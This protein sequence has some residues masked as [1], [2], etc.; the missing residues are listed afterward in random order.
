MC[1]PRPKRR[2]FERPQTI[3][4]TRNSLLIP[5]YVLV[6][7]HVFLFHGL[8]WTFLIIMRINV[9]SSL[10]ATKQDWYTVCCSVEHHKN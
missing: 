4:F 7:Y 1:C 6:V 10:V 5:V 3:T 9:R 8:P 2:I